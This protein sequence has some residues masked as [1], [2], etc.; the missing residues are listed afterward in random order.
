LL[1]TPGLGAAL[2]AALVGPSAKDL[3]SFAFAET[4][5]HD[6]IWRRCVPAGK[7]CHSP[8]AAEIPDNGVVFRGLVGNLVATFVRSVGVGFC[9]NAPK[10]SSGPLR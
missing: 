3:S 1:T 6:W 2:A 10:F 9:P 8:I 5:V 4:L 7:Q